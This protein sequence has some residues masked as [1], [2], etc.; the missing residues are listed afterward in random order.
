MNVVLNEPYIIAEI[1]NNHEGDFGN[2]IELIK[3]SKKAGASAAKFQTF[4]PELYHTQLDSGRME[5][6]KRFQLSFQE[7]EDL[8]LFAREIGLDFISTPFDFESLEFLGPMVDA[9]KISS[10]DSVWLDFVEKAST[11]SA[12]LII[13]TGATLNYEIEDSL[14]TAYK[15]KSQDSIY[16]LHC[17]SD[18]PAQEQ[19]S[20]MSQFKTLTSMHDGPMGFSDHTKSNIAALLAFSMGAKVFEKHITL[21]NNFSEFR[22]HQVA[23]NPEDFLNYSTSLKLASLSMGS[24]E[25]SSAEEKIQKL[26][27]RSPRAKYQIKKGDTV[28]GSDFYWVRP[29][30]SD[31]PYSFFNPEKSFLATRDIQEH[32]LVYCRDLDGD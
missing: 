25:L 17:T 16:L 19:N 7:F 31:I 21:D 27:R 6:L 18:Y 23:L 32:E 1:G 28:D 5:V 11:F 10:G 4:I 30:E 2:A 26:I 24:M 9:L 13:S 3:A 20:N 14:K 8:A 15:N 12:P 29:Q 22:D